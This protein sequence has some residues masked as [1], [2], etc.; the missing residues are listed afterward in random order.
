MRPAGGRQV[1]F[2]HH[3]RRLRNLL[4][5]GLLTG[6]AGLLSACDVNYYELGKTAGEIAR[7]VADWLKAFFKGFATGFGGPFCSPSAV[8]LIVGLGLVWRTRHAA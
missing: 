3:K 6:A 1:S 2:S 7:V 4:L 5:I 8:L